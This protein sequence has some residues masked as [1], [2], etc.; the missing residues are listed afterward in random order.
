MADQHDVVDGGF[1]FECGGVIARKVRELAFKTREYAAAGCHR[2]LLW[3]SRDRGKAAIACH[4][5][6]HS[7]GKFELHAGMAKESA[8]VM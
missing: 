4:H 5:C 7:L 3:I 8:I 6:G 1:A 2:I